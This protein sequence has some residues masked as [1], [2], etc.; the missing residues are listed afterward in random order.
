MTHISTIKESKHKLIILE[1]RMTGQKL[2]NTA[3]Q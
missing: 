2:G 3:K 1:A